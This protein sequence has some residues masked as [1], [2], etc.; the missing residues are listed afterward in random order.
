LL[1]A[2]PGGF[3]GAIAIGQQ[4]DKFRVFDFSFDLTRPYVFWA[5]VIGGCFLNMSTHGTDQYMVQR[6]LCT[7]SSRKASIAL[8]VSGG[9]ILVQFIGFLFIGALLFAFYRPDRL[10]GYVTGPPAFPFT[11]PDQVFPDFIINHVPSGLSGLIIAA[12]LAAAT[13]PSVNSIAATA[14]NDLYQPL[15]RDR[16]DHHYLRV[17]RILTVVAGLA[18]ISV[19]LML[20]GQKG[21]AVNTALGVASLINGPILG[22]FLLSALQREGSTAAFVGM[23]AGIAAV[24]SVWLWTPLAWPWYAVVGS[25]TTLAVGYVLSDTVRLT[26]SATAS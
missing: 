10:P 20:I 6:Y 12:V 21:S 26:N 5:G 2:I 17:S 11:T 7:T 22:V 4:A 13:S 9:V 25:L 16:S 1:H 18:Q 19:A 15:V 8:L 3:H 14:V 23:L 24:T